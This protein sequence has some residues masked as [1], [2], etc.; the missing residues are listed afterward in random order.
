MKKIIFATSN[1]GKLAEIKKILGDLKVEILSLKE[2]NINVNIE[3]N[4]TSFEENAI[5]KAKTICDLTGEIVFADDSGLEV[6]Y[7]DKAP[8]IYSARFLGENTPY[9][10]KNQYIIDKLKDVEENDRSARFVCVIACAFPDG[11]I[12]T[13]TGVI[14]GYIAKKI[15]GSNGFG[16]D[17]IFYVPEYNCTT[18]DMPLELKNNISHRG[19]ALQAMKEVLLKHI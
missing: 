8:G 6:D 12:I 15:S 9:S 5:I 2:A 10:V 3:E 17:P 13:R 1:E 11:N 14:E 4:G 18:A 16:Y 19:K 7:L